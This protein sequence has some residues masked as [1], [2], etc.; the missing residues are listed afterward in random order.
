MSSAFPRRK[1]SNLEEKGW[2]RFERSKAAMASPIFWIALS[3]SSSTSGPNTARISEAY[4]AVL[5][6]LTTSETE[7]LFISRGLVSGLWTC[8]TRLAA[9]PS[10]NWPPT[11]MK[12]VE[13]SS[14][15]S[16]SKWK[17]GMKPT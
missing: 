4:G 8:A 10:Q 5:T 7:A 1:S 17:E 12:L 6:F 15:V 13:P 2:K 9:R 3:S 14:P 16:S 11:G